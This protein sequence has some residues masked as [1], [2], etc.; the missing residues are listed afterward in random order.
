MKRAGGKYVHK[1]ENFKRD[2]GVHKQEKNLQ[3]API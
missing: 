2:S 3:E 1:K